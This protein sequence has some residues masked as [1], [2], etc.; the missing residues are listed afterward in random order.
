[1][2]LGYAAGVVRRRA[3]AVPA[4]VGDSRIGCLVGKPM[5]VITDDGVH[6]AADVDEH[7]DPEV[8]VVFA[9]GWMMNR[10]CW[11][12]QREA[13]AGRRATFVFYD[14]RGHG[15]SSTGP[16][17]DCT[18]DRL[19]DDLA[20]VIEQA[21]PDGVPVVLVGHSMG[22]MSIMAFAARHPELLASRVRGVAML[23]T[24]SGGLSR[25]T[26]GLPWPVGRI[27]GLI[28]PIVFEGMLARAAWIDRSVALKTRTHLPVARFIAFG[29]GARPDHVRFV[30]DVAAAT[31]TEV[32]VG[33]FRGL[34]VHD[35]LAA[36]TALSAVETLVMVG[37]DDRVTPPEHSRRIAESL[38]GARLTVVPG[39]GHMIGFERPDAVNQ[40]LGDFLD[41]ATR[42]ASR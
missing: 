37:E 28:T 39:A 42:L 15:A 24:S 16:I 2:A 30:S 35:K 26:F 4:V 31:P 14:Q 19:G 11:H 13:L 33:F 7:P 38:P 17:D 9:H 29:G 34:C 1:M 10:H 8:A 12:I 27:A 40:A 18:I 23:S 5:T 36:L 20:A 32:M 22:G 3:E 21:V 6:L 25:H 41:R